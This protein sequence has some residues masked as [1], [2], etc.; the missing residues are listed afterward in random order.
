MNNEKPNKTNKTL[1]KKSI[2]DET[3]FTNNLISYFILNDKGTIILA[4]QFMP[5]TKTELFYHAAFFQQ[6]YKN[7]NK[8]NTEN[9]SFVDNREY[10]YIYFPLENSNENE[11]L[12]SIL[13][14]K[15][16]YNIFS[17]LNVIKLIQRMIFEII[18]NKEKQNSNNTNNEK[19]KVRLI[20]FKYNIL[21]ITLIAKNLFLKFRKIF[22]EILIL[23]ERN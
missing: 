20:V 9:N 14:I 7:S 22:F 5:L 15:T 4:R 23:T 21:K 19:G 6:F 16:N 13:L 1:N 2:I 8:E 18:K 17:A 11:T 12:F 3:N 10:R